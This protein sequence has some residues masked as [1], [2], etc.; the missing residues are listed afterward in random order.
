MTN[1]IRNLNVRMVWASAFGVDSEFEF[2]V[3]HLVLFLLLL[4]FLLGA[5]FG[6]EETA[7]VFA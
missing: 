3:F 6:F 1:Q 5:A 4:Y 2:R 7:G